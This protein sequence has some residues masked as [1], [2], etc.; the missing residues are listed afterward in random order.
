MPKIVNFPK[1]E[2]ARFVPVG[3]WD[4][5]RIGDPAS[6]FTELD[7]KIAR[8]YN[9]ITEFEFLDADEDGR[10]PDECLIQDDQASKIMDILVDALDNDRNVLVHCNMG[11]CRSGAVVEVGVIIGF[12]D[13]HRTRLPNV[14]VK[15]KLIDEAIAR[16][17]V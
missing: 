8:R 13:P 17:L 16:N 1:F 9:S 6:W 11:L 3:P 5:I 2:A 7:P 14:R 4:L 10:F 12:D 15:R